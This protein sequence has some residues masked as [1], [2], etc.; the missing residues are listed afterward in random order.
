MRQEQ[1][2]HG[3][4]NYWG[5]DRQPLAVPVLAFAD[6]GPSGF[7]V[8]RRVAKKPRR[9]WAYEA[10]SGELEGCALQGD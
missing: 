10:L 5:K 1:H 6:Q 3:G 2:C 9:F 8:G 4:H 7:G